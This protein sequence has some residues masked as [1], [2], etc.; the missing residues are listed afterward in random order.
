[1]ICPGALFILGY[2]NDLHKCVKYSKVCHFADDTNMQQLD[3]LLKNVAKPMNFDLKS[4]CQWRKADKLSL[5]FTKTE[6]IMFHSSSKKIEHNLKFWLDGKSLTITSTVKYLG[7]LWDDHLLW[8]K[9]INYVT[10][11]L[12]QAIGILSKLRKYISWN[13][14]DEIPFSLLFP[15]TVWISAMG[16]YKLNR[17]KQNS[18][19]TEQSLEE[20]FV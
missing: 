13:S 3:N 17:P 15:P 7:V 14:E 18:E 1:M 2:I 4:L 19:V 10:A 11:K 8:L 9:Q 12:N 20:N 16:E 6:L 5:N